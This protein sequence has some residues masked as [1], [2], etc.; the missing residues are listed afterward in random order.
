MAR[1]SA[2][3]T[4]IA[5]QDGIYLGR[6][7][8]DLGYRVLGTAPPRSSGRP[9]LERYLPDVPVFEVDLRDRAG[10]AELL[11]QQRPDEIYNLASLSSVGRSWQLPVEVTEVNGLAVLGLLEQVRKLRDR[12]GYDPRICQASSS[13][14]F[15]AT[16]RLP[17]TEDGPHE[18]RSPYAAAKSFAHHMATSY[19]ENDAMF[20]ACAVLFNHESPLRPT[21]F[22][23][24]K[25]TQAAAAIALGKQE[26]LEL[27]RLDIR[28]DWGAAHDYVRA[29]HLMLQHPAPETFVVATGVSHALEDLVTEAFRAAG[30][31]DFDHRVVSDPALFRPGDLAETR[32]DPAKAAA[33]LSWRPTTS[34]SELVAAMVLADQRRLET[35]VED[36]PAYLNL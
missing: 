27:G 13:E 7:L 16:A 32:G 23:T 8:L 9:V 11:D 20:V 35:G 28:R 18:P 25:I 2:L 24:R 6:Y 31:S 15:G 4:G 30:V 21:A 5:G 26:T 17:Q 22:V 29:M 36:D 3:V 34:F 12:T 10:M 33:E 19:R 14:M 1:R